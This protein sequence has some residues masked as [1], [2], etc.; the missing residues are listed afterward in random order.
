MSK[1]EIIDKLTKVFSEEF[2]VDPAKIEGDLPLMETL[3]LDSLDLIDV[4]VLIEKNFSII[5]KQED[6]VGIVTFNDFYNLIEK[7]INGE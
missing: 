3:D 2:E 4:V 7:K 6:F 1:Q 5:L